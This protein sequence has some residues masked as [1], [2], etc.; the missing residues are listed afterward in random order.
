MLDPPI[1]VLMSVYNGEKYL[2][3]TIESILN[4]TFTN[5]EFLKKISFLIFSCIYSVRASANLSAIA[6]SIMLL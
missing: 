6:L 5:F 4:Q 3:E 2:P 1:T